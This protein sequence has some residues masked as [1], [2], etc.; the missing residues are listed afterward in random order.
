MG[1]AGRSVCLLVGCVALVWVTRVVIRLARQRH[2]DGHLLDR[3]VALIGIAVLAALGSCLVSVGIAGHLDET[4]LSSL[5]NFATRNAWAD[6]WR[7]M[8][9][10]ID[11]LREHPDVPLYQ[12]L[13]F[14]MHLKFI[15]PISSLVWMDLLQQRLGWDW[16][17]LTVLINKLCWLVLLMAVP[18]GARLVWTQATALQPIAQSQ[19]LVYA[20]GLLLITGIA[21]ITFYPLLLSYQA[22]QIQTPITLLVVLAFVAWQQRWPVLAGVLLGICCAFKPQWLVMLPWALLRRQVGMAAAL[23][24]TFGALTAVAAARYGTDSVTGYLSVLRYISEH[25]EAYYANQ[26]VNGLVNRLVNPQDLLSF[27]DHR[28]PDYQLPVHVSSLLTSLL[29]IGLALFHRWR[30]TPGVL[31]LAIVI[32][33]LTMASPVA[34]E[35]HY[36]VVL[37]ILLLLAPEA[38]R[39]RPFGRGSEAWFVVA[40]VLVADSFFG[41][42]KQWVAAPFNLLQ[43]SILFGAAMVLL[44]LYRASMRPGVAIDDGETVRL[45]G[46]PAALPA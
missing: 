42:T 24:A 29:L 21:T 16:A 2:P 14:N 31:D 4:S 44:M 11:H 10:A 15:Y 22:G 32:L 26:S 5:I 39:R 25:G 20:A 3:S 23:A 27:D 13:F 38:L 12:S 1:T 45:P 17:H 36:G 18:L 28:Y 35:H 9:T 46:P 33:S 37:P 43:S 30:E 41:V 40:F 6:S 34:W 19:R 7:F 8:A